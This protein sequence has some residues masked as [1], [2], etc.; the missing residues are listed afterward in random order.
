MFNLLCK[1]SYHDCLFPHCLWIH[2]S[3]YETVNLAYAAEQGVP[4]LPPD[5]AAHLSDIR[6][7][8]L[9]YNGLSSLQPLLGPAPPLSLL[10]SL[11]LD[12][13]HLSEHSWLPPLPSLRFLS[14][15]KNEISDVFSFIEW[16]QE[17]APNLEMVSAA[18]QRD[19]VSDGKKK[20][21]QE[22]EKEEERRMRAARRM[23]IRAFPRLTLLDSTPITKEERRQAVE[24][25]EGEQGG[26]EGVSE[27]GNGKDSKSVFYG[28][29]EPSVAAKRVEGAKESLTAAAAATARRGEVIGQLS[30]DT[31]SLVKNLRE[32]RK[33][34]RE[35]GR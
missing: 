30:S 29:H 20:K 16:L 4:L 34:A 35:S 27:E 13:N 12:G 26:R 2:M 11:I 31:H 21:S 23:W 10:H 18:F 3:S 28:R 25:R 5:V 19:R 24:E 14:L 8:D 1:N 7:F 15:N 9:S 6:H 32:L 17:A 22:D 33:N